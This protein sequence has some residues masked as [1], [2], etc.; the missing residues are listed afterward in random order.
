MSESIFN[1]PVILT[2]QIRQMQGTNAFFMDWIAWNC[3]ALDT[4]NRQGLFIT[5]IGWDAS[6][7]ANGP[8]LTDHTLLAWM[9]IN[10]Y[11]H[12]LEQSILFRR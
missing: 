8:K 1:S 4:V 11:K 9:N 7:T 3:V 10:T 12:P 5:G 6:K 2:P